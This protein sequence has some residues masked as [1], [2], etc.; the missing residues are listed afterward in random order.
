MVNALL[1]FD[2]ILLF[3]LSLQDLKSMKVEVRLLNLFLLVSVGFAI[4]HTAYN[5]ITIGLLLYLALKVIPGYVI[6]EGDQQIFAGLAMQ[7]GLIPV[8]LILVASFL[9]T[10]VITKSHT[11]PFIPVI[12]AAFLGVLHYTTLLGAL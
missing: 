8:A 4:Y 1:V 12:F 7:F 10:R 6:G 3:W 5:N 2:I 11:I 9:V